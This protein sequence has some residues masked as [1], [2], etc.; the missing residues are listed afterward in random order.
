MERYYQILGL[1]SNATKKEIKEAYHKKIKAIHPDKVHGTSLEDTATFL[2]TEIN[3]AYNVLMKQPDNEHSSKSAKGQACFEENIYVEDFGL[4][5]YS[6]SND[7][8]LIQDAIIMRTGNSDTSFIHRYGWRLNPVLSENVKKVMNKHN[9]NYSM[10]Y[11]IR[12]GYWSLVI[13]KRDGGKWYFTG[14]E[15]ELRET[16]DHTV[17]TVAERCA[18][19]RWEGMKR[20]NDGGVCIAKFGEKWSG[21]DL[22]TQCDDSIAKY[23]G[24]DPRNEQLQLYQSTVDKEVWDKYARNDKRERQGDMSKTLKSHPVRNFFMIIGLAIL[25]FYIISQGNSG[26][27]VRAA[28]VFATVTNAE[29]LNVRSSPSSINNSN[30]VTQLGRGTRVEIIERRGNTWVRIRYNNGSIGYVH[31]NHLTR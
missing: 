10:T 11:F 27:P 23:L 30:V 13:N 16:F 31:G 18:R 5:K 1:S 12:E 14:Y 26:Q 7:I 21:V 25:L 17:K 24:I 4:L 28:P 8:D 20:P 15:Q 3:E 9:V 2:S 22:C 29:W 19:L 6:L